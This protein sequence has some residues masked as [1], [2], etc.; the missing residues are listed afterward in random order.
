VNLSE[1][2][3]AFFLNKRPTLKEAAHDPASPPLA[4]AE[5]RPVRLSQKV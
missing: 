2:L 1:T 3:E 4:P 5:P